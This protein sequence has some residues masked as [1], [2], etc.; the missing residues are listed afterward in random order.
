MMLM[1]RGELVPARVVPTLALF[2]NTGDGVFGVD[3][4]LRLVMWNAGA[5]QLLGYCADDVLGSRCYEAMHCGIGAPR[6]CPLHQMACCGKPISA[7]NLHVRDRSN[8]A[9]RV[10]IS[11]IA[12][13]DQL[14][15]GPYLVNIFRSLDEHALADAPRSR[16]EIRCF[17]QFKMAVGGRPV[18]SLAWGRKKFLTVFKYLVAHAGESTGRP[19]LRDELVETFWPD[20]APAAGAHS[21]RM[22]LSAIRRVLE[23]GAG[24]ADDVP[25]L[26]SDQQRVCLCI[27]ETVWLDLQVFRRLAAPLRVRGRPLRKSEIAQLEQAVDLYGE[28]FLPEEIYEDW[29]SGQRQQLQNLYLTLL[30]RL[31]DELWAGGERDRSAAYRRLL[32]SADPLNEEANHDLI[33]GLALAG[34]RNGAI[35][36]YQQYRGLIRSELGVEPMHE[37]RVLYERIL[38]SEPVGTRGNSGEAGHSHVE[39]R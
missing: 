29:S 11:T 32:V 4:Q 37:T 25:R 6:Q 23:A 8:R 3:A 33:A 2:A 22:A 17:G 35:R 12:L 18:D 26:V 39:R 38:R 5:E 9:R 21:L 15:D 14:P 24:D 28:G 30:R 13:A 16:T 1:E 36:Q 31:A 10:S 19:I 20:L 27:P 34:D 7:H